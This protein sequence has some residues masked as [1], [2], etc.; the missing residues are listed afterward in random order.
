[1]SGAHGMVEPGV[2][3]QRAS[4]D[5]GEFRGEFL[6]AAARGAID[7]A[8]LAAMR[9]EPVDE[10]ARRIRFRPHREKEIGPVERAHEDLRPADETAADD[11]GAGRSVR[12]RG[13]GDRLDAAERLGD[14][15]QAQIFRPEVVAPLRDAMGLVDGETDRSAT[16]L[17][18]ARTSSRSSRSGAT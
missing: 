18:A 6:R 13:H 8:A 1:M 7:D 11:L 14:L 2:I 10:L 12:G 17:S 5:A 4:A 15:A 16:S 9:V 3:G